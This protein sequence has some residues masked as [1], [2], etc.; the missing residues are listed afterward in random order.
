YCAALDAPGDRLRRDLELLPEL[1]EA[2]L[3][4]AGKD[5]IQAGMIGTALMLAECSGVG[6]TIDLD[7]I[8]P[9]PGVPMDRWLRSFP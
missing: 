1:A 7:A 3:V 5:I 6:M 8:T 2:E 9:P 4:R